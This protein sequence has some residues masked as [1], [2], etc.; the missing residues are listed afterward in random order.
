MK[1]QYM[2]K[3]LKEPVRSFEE[4]FKVSDMLKKEFSQTNKGKFNLLVMIGRMQPVHT[5]HVRMIDKALELADRVLILVGS[6]GKARTIRNPFTFEERR[7]M[8][9]NSFTDHPEQGNLII[10]P[11]YDK[12]YNDT[13]WV[14]QVQDIVKETAL[15]VINKSGFQNHGLADMK[16]GVIG[17]VKDNT[18]YYLS[19]FPQWES[20]TVPIEHELH[21]TAIREG[22]FS[23]RFAKHEL[24]SNEITPA[25]ANFLFDKFMYSDEYNER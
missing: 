13:A 25:V 15:D 21:S 11:L 7:D 8:V 9:I 24:I 1:N 16:I 3:G 14:K 19:L 20:V 12:T 23:G 22:Y 6:S 18:S 4:T 5:E 17:A 2:D 10:K